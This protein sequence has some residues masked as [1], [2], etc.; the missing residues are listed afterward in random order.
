[1]SLQ[2]RPPLRDIICTHA[3][4]RAQPKV[5]TL[6]E[7]Q[8]LGDGCFPA[9][10]LT[11]SLAAGVTSLRASRQACSPSVLRRLPR[12]SATHADDK[13]LAT[14]NGC[15]MLCRSYIT[16]QVWASRSVNC[17]VSDWMRSIMGVSSLSRALCSFVSSS[18]AQCQCLRNGS[19]PEEH[20]AE[21]NQFQRGFPRC[22]AIHV[23]SQFCSLQHATH[24]S[25]N[26][27]PHRVPTTSPKHTHTHTHTHLLA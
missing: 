10:A 2:T 1:M 22:G 16:T 18:C 8:A 25:S 4:I 12:K 13:R 5:G 6:P 24:I 3:A 21:S 15:A 14:V 11:G 27:C 20:V 23:Q 17:V 26:S 7:Y 9:R 19:S